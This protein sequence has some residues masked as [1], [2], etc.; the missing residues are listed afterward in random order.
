[1]NQYHPAVPFFVQG[2][3]VVLNEALSEPSLP[4]GTLGIVV[5]G[6]TPRVVFKRASDGVAVTVTRHVAMR[7]YIDTCP[8]CDEKPSERHRFQTCRACGHVWVDPRFLF[9]PDPSPALEPS[10]YEREFDYWQRR[11][12]T[13]CSDV[14][15]DLARLSNGSK[16][17]APP[18]LS[19]HPLPNREETMTTTSPEKTYS[20][21][22][23]ENEIARV[24]H[25][26]RE[27]RDRSRAVAHEL[28][29]TEGAVPALHAEACKSL[30]ERLC[31]VVQTG[32]EAFVLR[33]PVEALLELKRRIA[34]VLTGALV[35]F[36]P[37]VMTP[38]AEEHVRASKLAILSASEHAEKARIAERLVELRRIRESR[39]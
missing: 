6:A 17:E 25:A 27:D 8:M 29:D 11:L 20:I 22:L 19:A 12:G 24:I 32:E 4:A 2:E 15:S 5:E 9:A 10:T 35:D 31:E 21:T 38:E 28:G 23:T 37:D 33:T 18:V 1:M 39:P 26:L 14:A 36:E 7:P 30:A 16:P 13:D 3:F 34:T